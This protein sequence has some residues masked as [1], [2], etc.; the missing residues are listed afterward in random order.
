MLFRIFFQDSSVSDISEY[1]PTTSPVIKDMPVTPVGVETHQTPHHQR[2]RTKSAGA[3]PPSEEGAFNTDGTPVQRAYGDYISMLQ[4]GSPIK[5]MLVNILQQY[6][7][8]S[9]PPLIRPPD[10]PRYGGH[11]R[12]VAFDKRKM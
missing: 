2:H 9:S 1:T 3:M 4:T 11:I 7:M 12:E 6:C 10:L 8:Y 5:N